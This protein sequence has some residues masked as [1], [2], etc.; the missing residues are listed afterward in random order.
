MITL[1]ATHPKTPV[2]GH[3]WYVEWVEAGR[4]SGS[5]RATS[6]VSQPQGGA[7]NKLNGFSGEMQFGVEKYVQNATDCFSLLQ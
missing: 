6:P 4:S 5:H 3:C 2:L 7:D 1:G